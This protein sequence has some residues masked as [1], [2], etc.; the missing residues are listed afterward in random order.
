MPP[1]LPSSRPVAIASSVLNSPL[2]LLAAEPRLQPPLL[3]SQF[4]VQTAKAD[5]PPQIPLRLMLQNS[6]PHL[7]EIGGGAAAII[8]EEVTLGY[9]PLVKGH[10]FARSQEARLYYEEDP[11]GVCRSIVDAVRAECFRG[12]HRC[13]PSSV[14]QLP[15]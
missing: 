14:H 10:P 7:L 13:L 15:A 5:P 9:K 2:L 4:A 1:T 8:D 11:R 12:Y 6:V 3:V